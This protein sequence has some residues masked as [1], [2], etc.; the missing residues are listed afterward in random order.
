MDPKKQ[1]KKNK[2][3]DPHGLT[4]EIF[5]SEVAGSDFKV[6]ILALMNRIKS[7]QIYPKAMELCNITSIWKKKGPRNEFKSYRGIFRVTVLRS[8]L[9]RLIYNDEYSKLDKSLTDCNVGGRKFRNIRDNI[10]A[11]NAILHAQKRKN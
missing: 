4:N 11:L 5:K 9:D 8:I 2:S 1:L 6:A 10:F 7:E 3:R